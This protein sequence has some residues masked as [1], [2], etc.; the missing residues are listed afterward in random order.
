MTP[1]REFITHSLKHRLLCFISNVGCFFLLY[2]IRFF[3]YFTI[4]IYM[5]RTFCFVFLY[6]FLYMS[7]ICFSV[8]YKKKKKIQL[9]RALFCSTD[10]SGFNMQSF[11]GLAVWCNFS[12]CQYSNTEDTL[13]G[14]SAI[15]CILT[16]PFYENI[17]LSL[18]SLTPATTTTITVLQL[19][20]KWKLRLKAFCC[21]QL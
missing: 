7:T 5:K 2:R 19:L 15:V 10:L 18:N 17:N 6:L 3:F 13:T 12:I 16:A 1:F 9:I 20:L 4:Y 11:L 21:I 8:L 14:R